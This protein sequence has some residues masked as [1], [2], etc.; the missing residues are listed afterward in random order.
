M[1]ITHRIQQAVRHLGRR[2][3]KRT[4]TARRYSVDRLEE[5]ALLTTLF[6]PSNYGTTR[7]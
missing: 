3:T 5:R 4:K 7:L 2:G 1:T 6:Y